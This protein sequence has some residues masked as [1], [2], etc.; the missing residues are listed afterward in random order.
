VT[1][2][3]VL[4]EFAHVQDRPEVEATALDHFAPALARRAVFLVI[5]NRDGRVGAHRCLH[6]ATRL[7]ESESDGG[8]SSSEM[9]VVDWPGH[10]LPDECYLAGAEFLLRL[11]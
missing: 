11:K 9:R 7:F 4:K 10:G 6:F 5:G 1:D 8:E 2:W 3:R